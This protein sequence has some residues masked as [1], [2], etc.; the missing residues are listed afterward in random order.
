MQYIGKANKFYTL[1]EVTERK[2][3]S[4]RGNTYTV[5]NHQYFKNISFDLAKA[6]KLYPNAII[7]ETAYAD[8]ILTIEEREAAERERLRKER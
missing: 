5:I 8:D 4:L 7:D 2:M 1:W 6:K 3:T